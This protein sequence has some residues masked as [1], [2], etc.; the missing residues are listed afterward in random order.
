M[1]GTDSGVKS[2]LKLMQFFM[3][4]A[5]IFFFMLQNLKPFFFKFYFKLVSE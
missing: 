4:V 3:H 2:K 5:F 1:A